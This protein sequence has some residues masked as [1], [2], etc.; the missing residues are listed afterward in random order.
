M[1]FL[2][3]AAQGYDIPSGINPITQLHQREMVLPAQ[4]ADN[5]RPMTGGGDTHVY[6]IAALDAP[7]FHRYV[8]QPAQR[9]ALI[10]S[11]KTGYNRGARFNG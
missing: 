5:V 4:L 9:D 11:I 10:S 2:P 6:N 7:S 1:S 8:H 3:A